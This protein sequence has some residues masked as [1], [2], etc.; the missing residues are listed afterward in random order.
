MLEDVE[1]ILRFHLQIYWSS[2]AMFR[3]VSPYTVYSISAL[4]GIVLQM[5]NNDSHG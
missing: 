3:R 5:V 2:C 1:I 4:Q